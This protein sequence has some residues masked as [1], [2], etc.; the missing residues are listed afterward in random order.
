MKAIYIGEIYD[1]AVTSQWAE[2]RLKSQA[3]WLFD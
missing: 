2:W 1:T 3:S